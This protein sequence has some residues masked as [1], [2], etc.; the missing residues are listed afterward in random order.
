MREKAFTLIELVV[1]IAIIAILASIVA[2]NAFRSIEKSKVA[3]AVSDIKTL[4]GAASN[5]Y[6]S[7]NKRAPTYMMEDST[8]YLNNPYITDS[9][10][11]GWNGAYLEQWPAHPWGGS[12]GWIQNYA[13]DGDGSLND[14]IV[15]MDD[16]RPGMGVADNQGQ[17]P[18]K[19]LIKISEILDDGTLTSGTVQSPISGEAGTLG[20]LTFHN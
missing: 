15:V 9:G 17:V 5:Y 16:D 6:V 8:T 14:G 2:P 19:A 3:R 7:T 10:D 1:V 12:Y 13:W 18:Q 20:A 4:Q 11:A